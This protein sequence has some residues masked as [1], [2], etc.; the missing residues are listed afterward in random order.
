[1]SRI[2]ANVASI[3]QVE[4]VIFT[5]FEDLLPDIRNLLPFAF[6]NK[7]LYFYYRTFYDPIHR[8]KI[9]SDDQQKYVDINTN[10]EPKLILNLIV[11]REDLM[12]LKFNFDSYIKYIDFWII[13]NIVTTSNELDPTVD[14]C[15]N[16]FKQKKLPGLLILSE[17]E[18]FAKNKN[19]LLNISRNIPGYVFSPEFAELVVFSKDFKNELIGDVIICDKNM[20]VS[21]CS[22]NVAIKSTSKIKYNGCIH[23]YLDISD[24]HSCVFTR[25]ESIEL[26][27]Y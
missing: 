22:V 18:S 3:F 23:E 26:I 5:I 6:C 13:N 10:N 24:I 4:E 9:Y 20:P 7:L 8:K 2:E 17:F 27:E 19:R 12:S 14:F 15:L 21:N 11:K 25:I 1:M 16:Y